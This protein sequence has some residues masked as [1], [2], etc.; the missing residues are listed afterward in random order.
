MSTTS[1]LPDIGIELREGYAEVGDV[2]LHYVDAGDGTL[3]VLLLGFPEP[4]Y[5]SVEPSRG[6]DPVACQDVGVAGPGVL[7]EVAEGA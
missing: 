7:W 5:R 6:Q 2:N 3:I 1:T 4:A